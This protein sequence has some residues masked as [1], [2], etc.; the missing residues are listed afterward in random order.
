MTL[1]VVVLAAGQGTRMRSQLPK[2]LHAVAGLTLLEHVARL[3]DHV[4][5]VER[6]LVLSADTHEAVAAQYGERYIYAIQHE[7]LG[8]GH[9]VMQARAALRGKVDEV[10]VLYGADPLMRPASVEQLVAARRTAN[11]VAAITTFSADPPTGYGRIVRDSAGNV[12]A[13]VEERMAT[14]EQRAITEVNQGVAVYAAEWLWAALDELQPNQPS[15]EYY[16]TDLVALALQQHGP[17]SV[18]AIHL[19]DPT[20][21]L[22]VN[23]RLQLAEAGAI[24]NQRKLQQLMADG[25]TIIDPSSTYIDV[26]VTVGMDSIIWPGTILRGQT[27]IGARCALGPQ[28][29]IVDSRLGD[30]CRATYSVI[31]EARMERGANIG[32]FGHLRKGAHL[33]EDV[34]MGNFGEVKNATLGPGTKMGHFSYVGDAAVGANVNIGAGTI[35]CNFAADGRKHRTEIGDNA[36]IGSDTLLRAPVRVGA[37]GVTGAGSVVTKDVPPGG[38]AVGMPARVIRHSQPAPAD[39]SDESPRSDR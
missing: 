39:S 6:V 1:G 9:A 28:T 5:A 38:V 34:H 11:A 35:T 2:V 36:F 37:G 25:V 14:P 18:A 4:A 13:I 7:R 17:G 21:A 31:E 33:L 26:D 20:E 10:L 23:D 12:Q 32:P 27:H 16:L 29:M 30:D 24:L 15:G 3:A 22:G 8:T 19:D